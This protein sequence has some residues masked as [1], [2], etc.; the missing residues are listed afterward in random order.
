MERRVFL[1]SSLAA[2]LAVTKPAA[3]LQGA[4]GHTEG[5]GREFYQLRRY[6]LSNG[7]QTKLCDVFLRDALV[8]ALNRLG[9][10]AGWSIQPHDRS[11]DSIPVRVDAVPLGGTSAHGGI[12][13]RPR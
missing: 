4:Q 11:G 1:G 8:P 9:I 6:Y 12:K 5:N 7:P 10:D 13:S 3:Y 2:A